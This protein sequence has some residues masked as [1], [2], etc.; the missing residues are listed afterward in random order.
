[1]P[2]IEYEV[3]HP[4]E[5]YKLN[6]SD[7]DDLK[8]EIS[9]PVSINE[10]ELYRYNTSS[11]FYNDKC[12]PYTSENGTDMTLSDRQNDF[13]NQNLSLCEK[14]CDFIGYDNNTKYASCDCQIKNVC[15]FS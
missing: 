13:I 5:F 3:Y 14:N 11:D 9:L 10:D 12:F 2:V 8:I 6:L 7:C 15:E 1:M 4:T